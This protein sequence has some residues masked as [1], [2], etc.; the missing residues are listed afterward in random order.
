MYEELREKEE[1][2]HGSARITAGYCWPW[3]NPLPDGTLVN[4]VKIGDF[5]MP[6][7][8]KGDHGIGEYP[9]W[10]R[11]AL[12]EKGFEQVGCIYTAQGFE[13]DYIGVIIGPDL[14][15]DKD[16]DSIKAN[17]EAT[18]DPTLKRDT[19]NF[20]SYVKNIYR[21]LLT[22]GMKGCYAYFIDKKVADYF[23]NRMES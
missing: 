19:S 7:E 17:I 14:V 23:R 22:R 8:T 6:W 21:V 12:V 15:Y 16:T 9:P 10:Y 2:R 11:W 3:N 20:E 1:N 18:H 5:E 4:D 13:F